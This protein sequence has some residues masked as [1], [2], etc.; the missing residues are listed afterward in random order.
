M[1]FSSH[2]DVA[3]IILNNATNSLIV[4]NMISVIE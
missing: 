4:S 1:N 2:K 3:S